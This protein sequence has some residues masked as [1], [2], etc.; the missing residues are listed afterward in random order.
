MAEPL[1]YRQLRVWQEAMILVE[2]TFKICEELPA[3]QRFCLASQMQRAAVSIPSNIAEGH[4]KR[5][6]KDY[7]RHLKIAAGSLAELETQLELSVRLGFTMK[8]DIRE[9]WSSSQSVARMLAR[10]IQ[11][12]SVKSRKSSPTPNA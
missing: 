6:S 3:E 7:H 4:A 2:L 10:L 9:V 5:S 1:G 8:G 11:S 12:V